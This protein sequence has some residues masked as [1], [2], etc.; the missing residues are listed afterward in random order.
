[1]GRKSKHLPLEKT[2][3]CAVVTVVATFPILMIKHLM[4]CLKTGRVYMGSWLRIQFTMATGEQRQ[5]VTLGTQSESKEK[6]LLVLPHFF[7][8]PETPAHAMA[9]PTFSVNILL[10]CRYS[11]VASRVQGV[12]QIVS[13][14]F[15]LALLTGIVV[16][17]FH[18]VCVTVI[19]TMWELRAK[20]YWL[21]QCK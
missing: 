9:P 7:V 21:L 20:K 6:W 5:L 18:L 17:V 4:N 3:G 2:Q 12:V 19:T 1:M 16:L 11:V 14:S 10:S 8:Q 15:Q 13:L